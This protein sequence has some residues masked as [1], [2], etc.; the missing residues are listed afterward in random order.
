MALHVRLYDL[1]LKNGLTPQFNLTYIEEIVADL[2]N[3]KQKLDFSKKYLE[4]CGASNYINLPKIPSRK[5]L[6]LN[7]HKKINLYDYIIETSSHV[8]LK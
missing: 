5:V 1:S 8:N 3:L 7:S 4:F 2:D 6:S